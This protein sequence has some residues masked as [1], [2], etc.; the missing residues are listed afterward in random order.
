MSSTR[1]RSTT[2]VELAW[3]VSR[4][5]PR[6]RALRRW[7]PLLQDPK[8]SAAARKKAIVALAR[9]LAVDL[10]R[11]ATGRVKAEELG[12]VRKTITQK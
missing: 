1:A 4:F 10:W 6:Y 9:R 11:M 8:A 7:G 12:L 5:Q 3:R 2:R